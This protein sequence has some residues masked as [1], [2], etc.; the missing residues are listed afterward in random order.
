MEISPILWSLPPQHIL[1]LRVTAAD[2]D[3]FGHVNNVV[4][5]GWMAR[6]AWSHSK[7]LGFDFE[8]YRQRDCGFVVTHHEID[9][10]AATLVDDTVHIATWITQNDGRLRLRRRFEMVSGD[11]QKR[12]ASGLSDFAAMRISTGKACRM[13]ADYATGY[14]V[15]QDG[16]GVFEASR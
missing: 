5:L 3:D 11:Q 2:I 16:D 4:Y 14:P 12:L 1:R 9:Y 10:H 7:A 13:P 15:T 8:A 6:A